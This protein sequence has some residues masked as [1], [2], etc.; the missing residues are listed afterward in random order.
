MSALNPTITTLKDP[1]SPAIEIKELHLSETEGSQV[2][3]PAN[4]LQRAIQTCETKT[5][6]VTYLTILRFSLGF[7]RDKC[8]VSRRFIAQWTGLL[9]QNVGRGIAGLIEKGLIEKLPESNVKHGDM[10]K[11][12]HVAEGKNV[13]KA[14]M[15]RNQN[16]YTLAPRCN[17]TEHTSGVINLITECI[18]TDYE[19]SSNRLRSVIN[20][21]TKNKIEELEE[22]SSISEELET[23]LRGVQMLH[24]RRIERSC[25]DKLLKSHSSEQVEKAL[26]HVQQHGTV[27]DGAA[28]KLPLS[29][30]TKSISRVLQIAEESSQAEQS[31]VQLI[32]LNERRKELEAE[33]AIQSEKTEREAEE[34]FHATF[35]EAKARDQVI[36]QLVQTKFKLLNP[37]GNVARKIAVLHW[38]K[39]FHKKIPLE[40]V[41]Q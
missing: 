37:N 36:A 24:M 25:I 8:T 41:C 33:Q 19:A 22:S 1:S 4:L 21:I 34:A 2:E 16:D 20:P 15:T 17:Q 14:E 40:G 6:L 39:K 18:Q 38:Y 29:Y 5:E 26:K 7:N 27:G 3:I 28:C 35:P 31:K 23:Y 11:L 32:T 12:L 10:Y 9:Y 30:L 13:T